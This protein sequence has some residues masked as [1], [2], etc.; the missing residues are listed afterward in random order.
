MTDI[1]FEDVC[2][3][4]KYVGKLIINV[5]TD[6]IIVREA[7]KLF[8]KNISDASVKCAYHALVH[9]E[10]DESLRIKYLAYKTEQD[11]YLEQVAQTLQQGMELPKNIIKNYNKYYRDIKIVHSE[12]FKN[13]IRKVCKFLNV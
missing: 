4:R 2:S 12:S 8:P 10:A 7:I 13:F 9:R 1:E 11:D 6:R 5:L 3:A